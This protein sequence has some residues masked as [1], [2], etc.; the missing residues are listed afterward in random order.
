MPWNSVQQTKG[1]AF[2]SSLI[3]GMGDTGKWSK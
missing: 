3:V 1:M 2:I